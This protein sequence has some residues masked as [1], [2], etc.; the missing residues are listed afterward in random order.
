MVL[1]LLIYLNM[2]NMSLERLLHFVLIP[3]NNLCAEDTNENN[4]GG[5]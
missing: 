3:F 5:S 2:K 4:M 1:L